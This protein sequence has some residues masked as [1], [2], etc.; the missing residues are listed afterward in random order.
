MQPL[1]EDVLTALRRYNAPTI[2]NAIEIFDIRPR[3]EGFMDGSIRSIFPHMPPFVGYAV[4]AKT[5]AAAPRAE[6]VTVTLK[7]M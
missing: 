3:N 5:P 7:Q 1:P 6:G 4:T 2:A